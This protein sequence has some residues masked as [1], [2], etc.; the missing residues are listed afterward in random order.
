MTAA[1]PLIVVDVGNTR[2]KLG[3]FQNWSQPT[4]GRLPECGEVLTVPSADGHFPWTEL[5]QACAGHSPL[6]LVASVNPPAYQ[7]FWEH[8]PHAIW[9]TPHL[10][11]ENSEVPIANETLHPGGVGKDRLIKGVAGNVLRPAGTPLI[12]I[13]SGTA[14]TVDWIT[15]TGAFAGGAILPGWGLASQALHDHTA[16]L[17]F[18]PPE[19]FQNLRPTATGTDTLAALQSGIYW[20][21]VGAVRE[22][23]SRMTAEHP[24]PAPQVL[25]TGGAGAILARELGRSA[26]Y[27]RNLTLQGLAVTARSLQWPGIADA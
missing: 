23:L 19:S 16:L 10:L 7:R 25:V 11:R 8:W 3:V 20:G 12:M 2:I 4:P 27:H 14:T 21:Q 18:V 24:G 1:P 5:Q 22:L 6:C 17:P 13:D 9:G 15:T 26:C